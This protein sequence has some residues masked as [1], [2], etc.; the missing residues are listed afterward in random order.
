MKRGQC[1]NCGAAYEVSSDMPEGPRR[2]EF[3]GAL[4]DGRR[5]LFGL[6]RPG[7]PSKRGLG[8]IVAGLAAV[9]LIGGIALAVLLSR[10]DRAEPTVVPSAAPPPAPPPVATPTPRAAPP[11]APRPAPPPRPRT[12]HDDIRDFFLKANGRLCIEGNLTRFGPF[13]GTVQLTVHPEGRVSGLRVTM[14]PEA[15]PVT[16]CLQK[17]FGQGPVYRG[18]SVGVVYHFGGGRSADG[19]QYRDGI[20]LKGSAI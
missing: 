1:Q 12:V 9:L 15:A 14:Q 8:V 18:R 3:C 11:P 13:A 17:A 2:C 6:Q 19:L 7:G 20:E 4:V 10:G 5:T 16:R